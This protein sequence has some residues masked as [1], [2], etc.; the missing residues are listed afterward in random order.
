MKIKHSIVAAGCLLLLFF[1]GQPARA[2]SMSFNYRFH[3]EPVRIDTPPQMGS[4]DID[5][6]ETARKNGVEGTV[7]ADFTLGEDGKVRDIRIVQDLPFGVGDAVKN[8]LGKFYFKPALFAGKPVAMS[9]HM[10]YLVAMAYSEDDKNVT[11]PQ[12]TEKPE[13]V[14]PSKYLAD[15]VK[16]KVSVGVMFYTDGTVR[17]IATNSVMAQEFDKAAAEAA[18]K[19]KFTPAVHKKS[20]KPVAQRMEVIYEFKP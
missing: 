11:K 1:T 4:L 3:F 20:K 16:G 12:I 18:S 19:I 13:A 9:V 8:S 6:P 5:Y 2:Q 10:D 17:V 7:K 14:Y 15:K